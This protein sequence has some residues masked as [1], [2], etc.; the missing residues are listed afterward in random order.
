VLPAKHDQ[1]HP[2][3]ISDFRLFSVI[4]TAGSWSSLFQ[5]PATR[6][7]GVISLWLPAAETEGRGA[8]SP[9]IALDSADTAGADW[10]A[11]G[12]GADIAAYHSSA[13]LQ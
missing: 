12:T 9:H 1:G 4:L 2:A 13:T 11:A 5:V 3:S 10:C 7:A 8:Y 6:S